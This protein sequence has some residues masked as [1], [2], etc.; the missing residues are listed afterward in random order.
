MNECQVKNA[1]VTTDG[2]KETNNQRR[3]SRDSKDTFS[4]IVQNVDQAKDVFPISVR[5][6]VDKTNMAEVEKLLNFYEDTMHWDKS[7]NVYIYPAQV[8]DSTGKYTSCLDASD[9]S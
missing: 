8:T 9:F 7:K 4:V 6:N 2:C 5:I 1:Q 3:R